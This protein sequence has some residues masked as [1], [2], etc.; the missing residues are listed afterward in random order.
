M[1]QTVGWKYSIWLILVVAFAIRL[2]LAF[3]VQHIVQQPP[4]RLCLI[5]GD[6]ESYW[7]LAEKIAAGEDY[8]YGTPPRRVMRMPGFPLLLA[9]PRFLFG[10]NPLATRLLLVLVGTLGCGLTYRLGC[11]LFGMTEGLLAALYTAVSPS[12]ALFSVLFLSE[13]AFAVSM[14]ASLIAAARLVRLNAGITL[15][16]TI[17]L[18]TV[19]GV[20]IG[21]ATYMRPTWILVGPGLGV[22]YLMLGKPSVKIRLIA[23]ATLMVGLAVTLAPW[24][25][26]NANV[27]GHFVPT[28]LWVG[29]SLYDGLN[30]FAKGDSDMDFFDQDQLMAKE[31]MSEYEMDHEY[32]R[33]AWA[34]VAEF[35]IRT[36]WLAMIKQSRYW[37]P[38]PNADQFSGVLLEIV[39][40]TAFLPLILFGLLG[41]WV[42]RRDPWLLILTT[43]PIFYFA[44]I[45]LL[46]VGSVRY[47]LPAEYPLAVLSAV[48]VCQMFQLG[49]KRESQQAIEQR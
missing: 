23:A 49:N 28:T 13:T 17:W 25:I 35:P 22:L 7:E 26:R 15:R 47:R 5:S 19:T 18:A 2:V 4:G 9:L 45:H 36:A 43:A 42:V 10:D 39:G 3:G 20:M 40:W 38:T 12:M 31:K 32:R 48:G 11:Q 8:A 30:P 24:T 16:Q 37:S 33:R 44:A 6:A 1:T 34:F 29:P 14:V 41:A 21:V 46:F 27:T